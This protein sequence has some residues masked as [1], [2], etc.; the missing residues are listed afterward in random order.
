MKRDFIV[1]IFLPMLIS[2]INITC[3][4]TCVFIIW[5]MVQVINNEPKVSKRRKPDIFAC[6][7]SEDIDQEHNWKNLVKNSQDC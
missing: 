4:A 5:F 2:V 1:D 7:L 3:I 6:Q